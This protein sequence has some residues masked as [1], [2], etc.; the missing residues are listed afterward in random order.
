MGNGSGFFITSDGYFVTN[1]HVLEEG[2]AVTVKSGNR[3]FPAQVVKSDP[4]ND[5]AILKVE[6]LF[7]CL[8]FGD[9]LQVRPGDDVFT[10]GFPMADVMG[11]A[12]KTTLGTVSAITGIEDDPTTFQISVQIQPGNSGSPLVLKENGGVIGVTSSSLNSL[13]L[14]LEGLQVPQNVNYA[15]KASYIRPLLA[16]IPG[17]INKLPQLPKSERP[18]REIQKSV[19]DAAGLV[20]VYKEASVAQR[21]ETPA[22]P[23]RDRQLAYRVVYTGKEGAGV[24]AGPGAEA[25]KLAALYPQTQI[26]LVPTG[27]ER[28]LGSIRWLEVQITGWLVIQSSTK[29]FLSPC[30]QGWQVNPAS[31]GFLSMRTAP[32]TDAGLVAKVLP[33]TRVQGTET[34]SSGSQRWVFASLQGWIAE[35]AHSGRPLIAPY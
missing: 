9:D 33:G 14:L 32:S 1:H 26:P 35:Q 3:V 24:R 2:D 13:Q 15:V 29:R 28:S 34:E 20:M 30:P 23:Q 5:I 12:P 25:T 11:E 10:V 18:W 6:G 4:R 21:R 8:P 31:D 27:K 22:L 7:P 19:E 16:T 17:L